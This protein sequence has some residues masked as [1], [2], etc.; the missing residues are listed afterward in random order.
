MAG[1]QNYEKCL[2]MKINIRRNALRFLP[3]YGLL[4]AAA[5]GIDAQ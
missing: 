2:N 5:K 3:P 1:W 4:N